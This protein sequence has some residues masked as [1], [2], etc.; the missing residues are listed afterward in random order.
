MD[1][2]VDQMYK[3]IR[4]IKKNSKELITNLKKI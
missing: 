4:T 3:R 2:Y 1:E